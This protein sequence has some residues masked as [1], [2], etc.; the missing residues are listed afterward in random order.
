MT[1]DP[2]ER[3][4]RAVGALLVFLVFVV[5]GPPLGGVALAILNLIATQRLRADEA[6]A[7]LLASYFFGGMQAAVVGLIMAVRH[8]RW[9]QSRPYPVVVGASLFAGAA[10]AV[11]VLLWF[12]A[13]SPTRAV[14]VAFLM[15]GVHVFAGLCSL[16]VARRIPLP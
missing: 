14:A 4:V 13:P 2:P 11:P 3:I 9:P 5:I 16:A 6:L 8:Y 1:R 10:F 15:L 7:F 12:S